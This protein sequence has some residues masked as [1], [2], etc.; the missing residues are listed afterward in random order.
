MLVQKQTG[1]ICY[2]LIIIA[3]NNHQMPGINGI[4]HQYPPLAVL[5]IRSGRQSAVKT[6]AGFVDSIVNEQHLD[7]VVVN[8]AASGHFHPAACRFIRMYARLNRRA[9]YYEGG[10]TP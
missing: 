10:R 1:S 6:S 3:P 9:N 8:G 2:Q 7:I 4:R 5:Q